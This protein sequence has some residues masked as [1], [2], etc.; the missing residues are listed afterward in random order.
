[1]PQP[2]VEFVLGAPNAPVL[3]DFMRSRMR[4]TFIMGPLGSGKTYGTIQRILAQMVEQATN[5]Q[6]VRPS[7][8]LAVRNT[9]PDLMNTTVKDFREIFIEPEMGK[10]KMGGLEPPTFHVNFWLEDGTNVKSEMIFLA[11]DRD[12]HVSKLRG[13][14]L[15]GGWLNETKELPKAVL[16]M[17]DARIGRYPS[18]AAGSV[19][20]TW[21]GIVGDTNAPDEDH[22][23]ATLADMPPNN[24]AFFRQPGGLMKTPARDAHGMPVYQ[25]NPEAENVE[26]LPLDY[27]ANVQQGKSEDW[28]DVNLCNEYGFVVDGKPVHPNYIDSLHCPG[29]IPYDENL[30]LQ[31]GLDFGR[32]PAAVIIQYDTLQ[33]RV[34]IIDE[35]CSD[36]MSAALFAP[37]LKRYLHSTYPKAKI[38]RIIGDPSGDGGNEATEDTVFTIFRANGL[39]ATPS[40]IYNNATPLRRAAV[41]VPLS[42]LCMDGRPRL[43]ISSKAKMTRKGLNGGYCYRRLRVSGERYAD[44]PDKQSM[45]SHPVEA[46]EYIAYEAGERH[47]RIRKNRGGRQRSNKPYLARTA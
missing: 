16:D 8:W 11:L 17:L 29:I 19:R 26:N 32:T 36:G 30:P 47:D 22:W 27:Y 28:I 24:W 44:K 14:Q 10:F 40:S 1:M 34:R 18:M 20:A 23:Y 4:N 43:L 25:L 21:H 12:D 5:A 31:I 45:Y 3:E 41:A 37:E 38:A 15:T 42:E 2:R 6:G 35:F 9:Y 39:P 46:L 33:A 7:R 13:T